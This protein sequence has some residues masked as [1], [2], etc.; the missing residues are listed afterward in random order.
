M[1]DENKINEVPNEEPK[2]EVNKYTRIA[3]MLALCIGVIFV[4]VIILFRA[5]F[6]PEAEINMSITDFYKPPHNGPDGYILDLENYTANMN[7]T[8]PVPDK[9]IDIVPVPEV[10]YNSSGPSIY[11]ST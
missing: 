4:I 5:S 11:H 9:V 1:E 2:K 3:V 10:P 7:I 6:F 8:T